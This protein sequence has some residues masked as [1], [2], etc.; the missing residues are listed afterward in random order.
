MSRL[1]PRIDSYIRWISSRWASFGSCFYD[2]NESQGGHVLHLREETFD[3]SEEPPRTNTV[4]SGA[5][6]ESQ[7][8]IPIKPQQ[9]HGIHVLCSNI[10]IELQCSLVVCKTEPLHPRATLFMALFC[11]CLD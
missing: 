7:H 4:D 9:H 5:I 6:G 8:F 3:C 2:W 1:Y 10:V 11:N